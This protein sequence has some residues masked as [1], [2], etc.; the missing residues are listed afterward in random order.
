MNYSTGRL[1]RAER[2]WQKVAKRVA[3]R[4]AKHRNHATGSFNLRLKFDKVD[5]LFSNK[6]ERERASCN[7]CTCLELD[8]VMVL[9][10]LL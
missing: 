10:M 7:R 3:K 2:E 5:Q 6:R 1:Q 8:T 9:L 4:E